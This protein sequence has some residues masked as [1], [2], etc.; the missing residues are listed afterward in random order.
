[1]HAYF[2]RPGSPSSTLEALAYEMPF[3]LV[4]RKAILWHN[5]KAYCFRKV[6][7]VPNSRPEMQWKFQGR[8]QDGM[9]LDASV[10]GRGPSLHRLPYV[11]TNCSGSFEVAN[12]SLASAKVIITGADGSAET[13][14]TGS[15]AVLEIV[16]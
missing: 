9:H 10:D 4:F 16:G 1:M 13:L 8:T 5:N 7:E 2:P 14:Q 11:K 15:G 6:I 3:G 12:N